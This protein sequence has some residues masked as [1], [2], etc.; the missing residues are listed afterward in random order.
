M[1]HYTALVNYLF[2]CSEKRTGSAPTTLTEPKTGMWCCRGLRQVSSAASDFKVNCVNR[3]TTLFTHGNKLLY[4]VQ[5][6]LLYEVQDAHL[7][8]RF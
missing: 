5:D 8:L 7:F 2:T 4:E 1:V 6:K 3:A